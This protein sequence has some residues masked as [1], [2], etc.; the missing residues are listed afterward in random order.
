MV[1]GPCLQARQGNACPAL[2]FSPLSPLSAHLDHFVSFFL[3][4]L[5]RVYRT[6]LP[7]PL[8]YTQGFLLPFTPFLFLRAEQKI[9]QNCPP[10]THPDGP[11]PVS[12]CPGRYLPPA[13]YR[14]KE[15]SPQKPSAQGVS[16][17]N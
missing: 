2:S 17:T 3:D 11:S 8:P 1:R 16:D 10:S 9:A 12:I 7:R 14:L 6:F 5:R 15:P 4:G 13:P